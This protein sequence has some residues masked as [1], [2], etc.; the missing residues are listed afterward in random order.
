MNK[1][2]INYLLTAVA[3]AVLWVVFAILLAS[4]FSENPSLAEKYPE[5]LASELRL[6]FGL[7][8]LLSVLFAGYWFYYGSQEKVAGELPAAKTTWRAMFFS[9]ILIAV[10]LTFVIIF[11]NTDEGIESQWFGIYFAVL[12]VLTF[13]LFWVTTFLFSPRTVKYIPFGK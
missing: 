13:V 11:L 6:I 1:S 12:C 4:Y 8:A 3:G 9:Q 7:G 2:P 10:V 5:D